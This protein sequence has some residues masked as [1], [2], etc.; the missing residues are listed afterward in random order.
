[1]LG[2]Y[3]CAFACSLER[4]REG[5]PNPATGTKEKKKKNKGSH[6]NSIRASKQTAGALILGA[7]LLLLPLSERKAR[8]QN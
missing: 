6:H 5:H 1:M 8:R 3:A 7:R 2:V 4:E